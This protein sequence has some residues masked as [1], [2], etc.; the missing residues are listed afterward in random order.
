MLKLLV[1]V[2]F[3]VACTGDDV[4]AY[5]QSKITR[6]IITTYDAPILPLPL[7]QAI[8]VYPF[9]FVSGCVGMD[10]DNNNQI[11]P[12]GIV[13]ETIQTLKN[14]DTVLKASGSSVENVVKTNVYLQSMDDFTLFNQEYQKVFSKDFPARSSVQVAMLPVNA[15]VEIEVIALVGDIQTVYC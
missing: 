5:R 6:K 7:N 9:V 8:V 4:E 11:V 10:K 15:K 2:L 13:P 1:V 14:L 3:A 12:G